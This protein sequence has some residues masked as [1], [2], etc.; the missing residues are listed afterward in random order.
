MRAYHSLALFV[1]SLLAIVATAGPVAATPPAGAP[2]DGLSVSGNPSGVK[3]EKP[4]SPPMATAPVHPASNP[5]SFTFT[6]DASWNASERAQLESWTAVGSPEL[7][8]L[9]QVA[10]PPGQSATVNIVRSQ[11][12]SYAG[13]YNPNTH[14]VYMHSMDLGVFMHELNHAVHG[15]WI[16]ANSVWE[17]GMARASEVAEIDLLA[18]Q[19][20]AEASSYFDLHHGYSYDEYYDYNNTSDVGVASGSIYGLGDPALVFLRYEQAGYAFGKILIE[21]PRAFRQFNAK[22]FAQP[23]GNLSVNAL[24]SMMASVKPKV[25]QTNFS[26]WYASQQIFNTSPPAGCELYQRSSQYTVDLFSRSPY[27]AE[28]PLVAPVTLEVFDDVD[29][30]LWSATKQT[31]SGYGWAS[32]IPQ[33]GGYNGRIKLVASA[34]ASCGT[35]HS[36]YYR[37]SGSDSGI[38]GVVAN[39]TS[40]TVTF[41]SPDK[42]F[43]KFSVPVIHGAFAAPDLVSIA[44]QVK[45]RFS[46]NGKSVHRTITKDASNYSVL[47]A[48]S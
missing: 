19:G 24:E 37:Q 44:G 6:I 42:A 18:A 25:E 2:N 9:A 13:E 35:A 47:L 14:T 29:H 30:L 33:L 7:A 11:N 41:S 3:R 15:P 39:A 28:T 20:I 17:E 45:I 22:L 36:T 10:G 21:A 5:Q 1:G 38:F 4:A 26:A 40:G 48:A 27:G 12:G 31:A 34:T 46:G 16:I 43:A 23:N 8:A 32:F